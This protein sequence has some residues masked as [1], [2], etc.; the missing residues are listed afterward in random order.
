MITWLRQT[1]HR[2]HSFSAAHNSTA[3][4]TPKC[5]P[6]SNSPS[7]K[8]SSAAS[9]PPRPAARPSSASAEHNK[10]EKNT[11]KPAPCPSSTHCSRI[12][13]SPFAC[14]AN[15]RASPP[16]PSSPLPSASAPTPP[17]SASS[18]RHFFAPCRS[19]I[20]NGLWCS[21]WSALHSPNTK[22]QYSYMSCPPVG[23]GGEHGCSFSYPMFHQFQALQDAFFSVAALCG[24]VGLN[25]RGNGPA[26]FV[27]GEMVSG[28]F[29]DTLRYALGLDSGAEGKSHGASQRRIPWAM[30]DPRRRLGDRASGL[31]HSGSFGR[32]FAGAHVGKS[33]KHQSRF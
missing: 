4:S 23:V 32:R 22:G 19:A 7:K 9:L 14:C 10:P 15:P 28:I 27:Q 13:A 31:R 24:N 1:S 29:F 2:L 18:T 16:S 20:H 8:I 17:S 25:L 26:T 30:V 33:E 11:A 3:N 6:T 21:N 12:C 5:P